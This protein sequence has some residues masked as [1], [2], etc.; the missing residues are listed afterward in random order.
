MMM[1]HSAA[2]ITSIT[3]TVLILATPE[4]ISFRI[5]PRLGCQSIV[6][7]VRRLGIAGTRRVWKHGLVT[8]S[9]VP[10]QFFAI[11]VENSLDLSI[12]RSQHADPREHRRAA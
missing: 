3:R 11:R 9:S 7:R 1:A 5:T 2:P 4:S 6:F 8:W 10:C 12:K